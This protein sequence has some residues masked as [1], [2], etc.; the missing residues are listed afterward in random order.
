MPLKRTLKPDELTLF[1]H[2]SA[3]V[4]ESVIQVQACIHGFKIWI[5]KLTLV[6]TLKEEKKRKWRQFSFSNNSNY[7][8]PVMVCIIQKWKQVY[9]TEL[10]AHLFAWNYINNE[11]FMLNEFQQRI[12]KEVKGD[13]Y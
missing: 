5:L 4:V 11:E 1:V 2:A 3:R 12:V 10:R 8:C 7:M 9:K 6:F 13:G